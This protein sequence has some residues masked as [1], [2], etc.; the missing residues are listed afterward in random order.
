[1]INYF[2]DVSNSNKK[3]PNIWL[4]RKDPIKT[5][6]F[7]PSMYAEYYLQKLNFQQTNS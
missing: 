4:I 2:F 6:I 1:M 7:T 5:P 3:Y